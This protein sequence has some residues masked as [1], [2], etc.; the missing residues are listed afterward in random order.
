MFL[1]CI[2]CFPFKRNCVR[3]TFTFCSSANGAGW[4]WMDPWQS[5]RHKE[6]NPRWG[7]GAAS[8]TN[9]IADSYTIVHFDRTFWIFVKIFSRQTPRCS[10]LDRQPLSSCL[11]FLPVGE[12]SQRKRQPS[13]CGPDPHRC[14]HPCVKFPLLLASHPMLCSYCC[15]L[16]CPPDSSFLHFPVLCCC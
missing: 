16:I 9:H 3:I 2:C 7:D 5:W 6:G 1:F 13:S 14:K 11:F 8:V 10:L 4:S 15:S 12:T